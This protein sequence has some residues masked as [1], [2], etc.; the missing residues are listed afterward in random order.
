MRISQAQLILVA[1]FAAILGGVAGGTAVFFASAPPPLS[2]PYVI[3]MPREELRLGV[4]DE[5]VTDVVERVLP[6]V[7]SI[8]IK[9]SLGDAPTLRSGFPLGPVSVGGGTGFFISEDGLVVTNRHVISDPEAEYVVITQD[10]EEYPATVLALDPAMDLGV[11]KVEGSGF[12]AL[13]LG[14]SDA[15]KPGQ[16]VIAIGNALAEFQNSVTKGVVSGLNRR[17]I[18]GEFGRTELIEEAIQTD[19]AINP[20]NS[21]GPLLTLDG[22]VVGMNT[23]IT[24]GAQSLGFALPSNALLRAVESARAYGRIVRP[25]IGVRYVPVDK[26]VAESEG[27]DRDYGALVLGSGRRDPGVV[28]GSPA[29]KAGLKERDVILEINGERIGIRRSLAS[30]VARLLPGETVELKVLRDGTER[31]IPIVLEE[32]PSN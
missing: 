11:L 32:R 3:E 17:L 30:I 8:D 28:P 6:S 2:G 10:G 12:P 7:V 22:K 14:N 29:E 5:A 25:W 1:L 24:D 23:A 27:L 18:A 19:A 21:G 4:Q 9:Q 26:E 13:E 31:Q 15:I 16:T 20:G